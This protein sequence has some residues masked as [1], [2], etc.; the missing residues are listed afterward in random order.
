M[1]PRA[2]TVETQ[3]LYNDI[4]DVIDFQNHKYD[5]GT[6]AKNVDYWLDDSGT[7]YEGESLGTLSEVVQ[8]QS[9]NTSGC[10][11]GWATLFSGYHPT[12]ILHQCS[13]YH[14]Q[15]FVLV[16]PFLLLHQV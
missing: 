9:C 6:W 5:Q 15:L 7:K 3:K 12:V 8:H 14:F 10:I 13:Q 2:V 4:A 11:A 1:E 16:H